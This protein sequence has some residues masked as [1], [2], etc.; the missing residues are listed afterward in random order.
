MM[1]LLGVVSGWIARFQAQRWSKE[2]VL[3]VV[4]TLAAAGFIAAALMG[5]E[6]HLESR[7]PSAIADR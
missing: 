5:Q 3:A 6:A 7:P 4:L 1:T 2:I